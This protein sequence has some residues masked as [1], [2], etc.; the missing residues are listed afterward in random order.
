[1]P[2]E[3]HDDESELE[4]LLEKH[5]AGQL[6]GQLGQAARA[7]EE[8]QRWSLRRTRVVRF[9]M[10]FTGLAAAAAIAL[11]LIPRNTPATSAPP[12]MPIAKT[13]SPPVEEPQGALEQVVWSRT[14]DL[15]TVFIDGQTPARRILRE[16]VREVT[17]TDPAGT[18]HLKA[19]KP[20]QDVLLISLD[21]Y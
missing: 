5:F 11:T 3:R 8:Q 15:G 17:W 6:D 2:F 18:R 1:M 7:F 12:V 4:L 14:T 16:R 20:E 21:T 10:A 19:S 13:D 9:G